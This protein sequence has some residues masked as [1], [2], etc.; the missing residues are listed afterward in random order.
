[1]RGKRWKGGRK[2]EKRNNKRDGAKKDTDDGKG[3]GT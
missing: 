2:K 1:M 3:E